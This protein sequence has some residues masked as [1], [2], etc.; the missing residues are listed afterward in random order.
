MPRAI[1]LSRTQLATM[2][3]NNVLDLAAEVF[4]FIFLAQNLLLILPRF[5][6]SFCGHHDR[7]GCDSFF[8]GQVESAVDLIHKPTGIR[9]FCTQERSQLKNRDLA[10]K[11][12]RSKLYDI[13]LEKQLSETSGNRRAQVKHLDYVCFVLRC[14][15]QACLR[16]GFVSTASWALSSVFLGTLFFKFS[17]NTRYHLDSNAS[18]Y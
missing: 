15:Y 13:E 6:F 16:Y 18:V 11:L 8:P 4:T 9:I 14:G 12:L 3:F 5:C 7:G 10:M 1:G 17:F 2:S